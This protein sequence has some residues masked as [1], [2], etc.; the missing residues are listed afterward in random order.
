VAVYLSGWR[1]V[2]FTCAQV[3]IELIRNT[4]FVLKILSAGRNS[5]CSLVC[6]IKLMAQPMRQQDLADA[7]LRNDICETD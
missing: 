7:S 2:D 6:P 3:K 4:Y 1:I 5:I